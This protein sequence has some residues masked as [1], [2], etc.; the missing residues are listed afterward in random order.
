MDHGCRLLSLAAAG[1]VNFL[2]LASLSCDLMDVA[3]EN[4][5]VMATVLT[6]AGAARGASPIPLT[7]PPP[8][9]PRS[10][11]DSAKRW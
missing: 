11:A 10:F 8:S 6:G 4:T 1:N 2:L 3:V 5:E 7:A 9:P